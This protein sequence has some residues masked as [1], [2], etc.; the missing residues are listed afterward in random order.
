MNPQRPRTAPPS[1]LR[2]VLC[3]S[4]GLP[5]ALVMRCLARDP[6]VRITGLVVSS[7]VFGKS[8]SWLQ[9]VWKL[10]RRSGLRYLLYLWSSTGLAALLGRLGNLP[11]VQ[12]QAAFLGCPVLTTR[13]VND[14]RGCTFVDACAP[15]LLVS[16]FFNQRITSHVFNRPAAGAVNIHP[17][18]LPDLKGVDPM[19]Y[20]KLRGVKKVGVTLHR[21]ADELDAGALLGQQEVEAGSRESVMRIT[22][23]LYQ[24]GA[25]MLLENLERI[26]GG[27]PG[28]PQQ[29][30]GSYDSWPTQGQV[31]SLRR[32]GNALVTATDLATIV[33]GR[34]D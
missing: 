32:E 12:V 8:D 20:A 16:A 4:G 24:L 2:I 34:F 31:S 30:Q 27:D 18:L 13:D 19:F 23:R 9:S 25:A 10:Y 1:P 11:P 14:D 3:T 17:S 6:R 26:G 22:S 29:G 5:G 15:D 28:S 33:T 21:L 7:R